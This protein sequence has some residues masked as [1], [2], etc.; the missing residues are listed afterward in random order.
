MTERQR[1]VPSVEPVLARPEVAD[2][3]RAH[4]ARYRAAHM[5]TETQRK[6]M[7][8]IER[9][10]TA[11]LG[12]HLEVCDAC[13]YSRPAYNSCRDRHCPKCQSL[14]Q[15]QWVEARKEKLLPLPYFHVV[16]TLPQQLRRLCRRNDRELYDLLFAS[17]A[18]TLL[19]LGHDEERLDCHLGITS[20]LHTWTRELDYHPHVHCIVTAGGL[21]QDKSRFVRGDERF[22]FP[23]AVMSALYR[24]VLNEAA[25]MRGSIVQP[26][27]G[28]R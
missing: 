12:G 19:E 16:F 22:L 6:V 24:G 21:S 2:V 11:Q 28:W 4:G 17:A 18:K 25:R 14:K 26:Y 5:L 3:F 27:R 7:R 10:R 13:G 8:A 15:A 1:A 23:V 9:C 20:V